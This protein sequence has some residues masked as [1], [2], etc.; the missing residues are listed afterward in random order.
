MPMRTL[1]EK[2]IIEKDS[3]LLDYGAGRGDDIRHLRDLGYWCAR[4]YEP[5]TSCPDFFIDKEEEMFTPF[6]KYDIVTLIYVVNVIEGMEKRKEVIRR[7][8][9]LSNKHILIAVRTEAIKGVPFKDGVLTK[10]KTFQKRYNTKELLELIQSALGDLCKHKV[11]QKV[12][13]PGLVL[14]TKET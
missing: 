13:K 2:N 5:N 7:A 9:Y 1:I 4:G 12:I 3:W 14:I 11:I 8:F 6:F 10:R